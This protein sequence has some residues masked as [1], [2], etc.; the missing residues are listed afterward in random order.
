MSDDEFDFF[1]TK[2]M[3]AI[4]EQRRVQRMAEAEKKTTTRAFVDLVASSPVSL[5]SSSDDVVRSATEQLDA[6][7]AAFEETRPFVNEFTSLVGVVFHVLDTAC[8][9][10]SRSSSVAQACDQQPA[11]DD[12]EAF[13][14]MQLFHLGQNAD[15][16]SADALL[17]VVEQLLYPRIAVR[18]DQMSASVQRVAHT[19]FDA[20]RAHGVG[21]GLGA[22]GLVT[23]RVLRGLVPVKAWLDDIA[24]DGLLRLVAS[25]HADAV[26]INSFFADFAHDDVRAATYFSAVCPHHTALLVPVNHRGGHW[27]LCVIKPQERTVLFADSD[28]GAPPYHV[29]QSVA[30]FARWLA[31]PEL[32]LVPLPAPRQRD[33]SACGIFTVLAAWRLLRGE[34]LAETQAYWHTEDEEAAVRLGGTRFGQRRAAARCEGYRTA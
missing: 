26:A 3:D 34:T 13:A 32:R 8:V 14:L 5:P 7:R 12:D 10:P 27:A 15:Y 17:D 4:F 22:G 30:L 18:C 1:G 24:V 28:G 11:S 29:R 33:G 20:M 6:L 2:R 19:D 31:L 23:L 21:G 25:E 9:E 16:Y